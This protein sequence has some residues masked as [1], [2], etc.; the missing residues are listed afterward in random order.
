MR[1]ITTCLVWLAL[2]PV[3]AI[4]QQPLPPQ[5]PRTVEGQPVET[6]QHENADDKPL[7]PD[8]PARPITRPR[9]TS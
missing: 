5:L 1:R 2:L 9:P 6:R 7:S 8:R 3:A 4:A